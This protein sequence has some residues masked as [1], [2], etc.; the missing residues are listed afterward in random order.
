MPQGTIDRIESPVNLITVTL[1][2]T[3]EPASDQ[4]GP[5][6]LVIPGVFGMLLAV[7]LSFSPPTCCRGWPR[8]KR[9][10]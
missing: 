9:T 5:A 10:A 3:G 2:A 8:R 4:G 6:N 7:T 1:T